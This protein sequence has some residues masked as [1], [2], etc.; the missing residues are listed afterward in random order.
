MKEMKT[1][2]WIPFV[3][4]GIGGLILTV[5]DIVMKEWVVT[6]KSYFY[7]I[8]MVIYLVGMLFLAQSF[9]YKNIAVASVIFVLFNVITLS[10]VSWFYFNEKLSSLE[11]AGMVM[12]LVSIIL[13]EIG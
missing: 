3:L 4:L 8:G 11:M 10:I 13:L 5:G 12:G 6:N 1:M 2:N 7:V 9:K